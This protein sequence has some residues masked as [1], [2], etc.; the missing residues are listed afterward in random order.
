MFRNI[1]RLLFFLLPLAGAGQTEIA[2]WPLTSDYNSFDFN[3]QNLESITYSSGPGISEEALSNQGGEW[4]A[5]TSS[6]FV[7]SSDYLQIE[8][9]PS[10]GIGAKNIY[11]SEIEMRLR[12]VPQFGFNGSTSFSIAYD[13]SVDFD[14]PIEIASGSLGTVFSTE[15]ITLNIPIP[16][17][18]GESFF[19][20]IFAFGSENLGFFSIRKNDFKI[21]GHIESASAVNPIQEIS[22]SQLCEQNAIIDLVEP[23]GYI[24]DNQTLLIFAKADEPIVFGESTYPLATYNQVDPDFSTLSGTAFERDPNA[25]LVYKGVHKDSIEIVNLNPG[26]TYY[27]LA[28]NVSGLGGVGN[29]SGASFSVGSVSG[30]LLDLNQM[31]AIGSSKQV[32]LSFTTP[33]CLDAVLIVAKKASLPRI[34]VETDLPTLLIRILPE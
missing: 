23:L 9:V 8:I 27:F 3:A 7:D 5:F 10:Q 1:I 12:Q 25:H 34:P 30:A 26:T 32:Q 16:V 22:V 21:K 31:V 28:Y 15:D 17:Y 6:N 4:S 13:K 14:N 18:A 11:V 24:P 20:R 29:Y 19:L 2:S 33:K